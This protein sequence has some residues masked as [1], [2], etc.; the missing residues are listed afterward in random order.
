M[1]I[2]V[3]GNRG[4]IGRRYMAILKYLGH[5]AIGYDIADESQFPMDFDRAII[6][7]PTYTHYGWCKELITKY[8]KP[9]LVEKPL[10]KNPE[11]IR[12]IIYLSEEYQIKTNMVCNWAFVDKYYQLS[13]N[14]HTI[15]YSNF[16]TGN[17]GLNWDC[18]QLHYL[19]RNYPIITNTPFFHANIDGVDISYFDIEYSY[20]TMLD[21][22]LSENTLWNLEDALKATL[23]IKELENDIAT[24]QNK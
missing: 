13:P 2:L 22:W 5:E 9:F 11:E 16:N 15:S 24:S 3:I 10:S 20:I 14:T 12:E 1:K 4:S 23:K 19:E 7:T 21:I 6:A 17:D 8:K 18:I